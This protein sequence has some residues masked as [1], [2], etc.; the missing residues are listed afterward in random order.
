MKVR[1][2]VPIRRVVVTPDDVR[3]LAAQLTAEWAKIDDFGGYRSIQ[4]TAIAHDGTQYDLTPTELSAD[5]NVLDRRSIEAIELAYSTASDYRV[6]LTLRR[7]VF[8]RTDYSK[9]RVTGPD[10]AWVSGVLGVIQSCAANWRQR[11]NWLDRHPSLSAALLAV[12][13]AV[14]NMYF[15]F[16]AAD[17]AWSVAEA[18]FGYQL[19]PESK[20]LVAA[21]APFSALAGLMGAV[22]L[23]FGHLFW[24]DRLLRWVAEAYPSVELAM[25]PEH[26]RVESKRRARLRWAV[27][28]VV[29]PIALALIIELGKWL[30]G[31]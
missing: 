27:S 15:L 29:V 9:A 14:M 17:L 16:L 5:D 10:E 30:F 24:A 8:S 4:I 25:G 18:W 26:Q 23:W 3:E 7:Q 22:G 2:E 21:V 31:R 20:R 1:R 11:A 19:P 28:V 6:D 12:V 13:F